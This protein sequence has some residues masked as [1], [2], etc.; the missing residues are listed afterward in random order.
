MCISNIQMGH[1]FVFFFWRGVGRGRNGTDEDQTA[2]KA[3]FGSRLCTKGFSTGQC[4][5]IS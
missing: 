4:Y 5:E 3:Q 1:V 2:K